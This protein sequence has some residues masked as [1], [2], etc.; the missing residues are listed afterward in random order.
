M[1]KNLV[2][3]ESPAKAKTIEKFLGK[4]YK[5]ASS[6]GH[7]ADLPTKEL[8]VDTEGDFSP[9]YIVSKDKKDVVRKLKGLAKDAETVWL[10]SDEDREGEAI[11]WH[12]AE[13]LK[14][15]DD[16]TKRIVFHEI[17]KSAILNAIENPRG[18]NYNLVNAQQA[19]RV[20]DRLVGYE[21]S[22]VLWRKVKGGLSA[23]RVQS[24]SVRLI[25]EREREIE[26]FTPEAS[27]RIDAEFANAEGK[28][29]R[30]KLPKNF[31]TKEEA[32]AF[33]KDNLGADFKVVD[34]TKKPAKKSP[35]PPF[36]TSTLQQEASRKLYF[37]VSKTMTLAQRLYEA[38][39]ITYMRT[40]SVNLSDDARKGAHREIL[41]AYGEE[42]AK[43]RQ[44]K[45]KTKGA[46]EAH[47]AI[48]P[49]NFASHSVRA[50]RDEQR[51]YELIWK[52]AI[53]SQMSEAQ[54]ERTNVKIE[55]NKH[56]KV[57][58]AN[59]EVLKFEGFL[60]VY[61]EGSDDEDSEEQNGML[62]DMKVNEQLQNIFINATERFTRPPY[63]YTEASLVKKLEELGIGR[64]STYA[65][66][67]S[68]IQNR[69][70]IEKGS[71]DGTEREYTQF[72]LENGKV[73]E[74]KLTET[75]GSDK[76]KL[77]PTAV[78][79]VVND[80]L[81][82]HFSNILDYNF[83]AKVEQSF[84]DIAEGNEEWTKM[85]KDFYTDFHPHVQDVA[86]NADREVGERIL[87]EDPETGKP[88]S[89]RLG[90]F[91]PMVQIG[92]VEDD[93]KPKFASL[94]PDQT[95]DTITYEEA[96][97]LFQLPKELGEYKGEKVE[98]NNGRY[99]PYV[100]FGKKYVSLEK[101]EDPMSVDFD[102][103]MELI[104]EKEKADAP[105]YEYEDKPVQKGVGR[106]GPYLK[107]NGIFINVNKKY[108]F[109]N[110]SDE[111]IVE[112]IEDKK[113]KEREKIIHHWED[114]GI[115]VEKARWGRSNVIKGKTKVELPKT[116][117]A[118]KITLEEA[119]DIIAKKAPKK[120][121]AKK[122]TK[123]KTAAKKT[124][125]KTTK[126]TSKK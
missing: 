93:E 102:R 126:K 14:L 5:V 117:D 36:T 17:T 47:E 123:K 77:V 107:W 65:P 103:A 89:V 70:Y 52:R 71:V 116:V 50:D 30:A 79:K 98:V 113:R 101:G 61:L 83:T 88:V 33:L 29:F 81:V 63:R 108:D 104:K 4:D 105:I 64:P 24:V 68:T 58:T 90:K 34:L 19:R 75:V 31:D 80:F 112:L 119:K 94:S 42:Y 53:A 27:Y 74:K 26:D 45:G 87:G 16:R 3:V 111:D 72:T 56:D 97:D 10:A 7:I 91:G 9:K 100:R 39:H 86:K 122:T 99:G 66:T 22:P 76:G 95:L 55:A 20:L 118:T 110:L 18:I 59:G 120:K 84:D 25:V 109:D 69:N 82:N 96:M 51:L 38:G 57:F 23:G 21:L 124:T 6:F 92:S 106:F 62:P 125:K 11:A 115:R 60:K 43:S 85:M 114:E 12:L 35:A 15:K 8:G 121:A 1:A 49:T 67:I 46:Q 73:S 41:K 32:E 37:S 2:I 48:R 78:G 13:E 40:D 44:F 54:L 28:T